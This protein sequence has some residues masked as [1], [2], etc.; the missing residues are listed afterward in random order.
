MPGP[1][2]NLLPIDIE[3]HGAE[4]CDAI[5]ALIRAKADQLDISASLIA[6]DIVAALA[7]YETTGSLEKCIERLQRQL[8]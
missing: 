4:I 1:I 7:A 2:Q 8:N 3:G 6:V 5:S